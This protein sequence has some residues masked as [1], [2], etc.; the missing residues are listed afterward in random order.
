[1]SDVTVVITSCNR[2]DLLKKTIESFLDY[3][4]Y[5]IH[6]F[7]IV[8]DSGIKSVNSDL[9]KT[10]PDFNW[11]NSGVNEGQILSIDKAYSRVKTKYIFHLED[12][13]ETY[14]DGFIKD[15]IYK[16]KYRLNAFEIT[17]KRSFWAEI[18]CFVLLIILLRISL[19]LV[20]RNSYS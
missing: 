16:R 13:W 17:S 2:I 10:Y 12:D 15:S 4:T 9:I 20:L 3:N 7:I 8:E 6:E 14:K 11:I 18:Y 1:M 19:L 5:P